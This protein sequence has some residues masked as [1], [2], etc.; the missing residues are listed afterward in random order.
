M[1]GPGF[2]AV[3][4]SGKRSSSSSDR[5]APRLDERGLGGERNRFLMVSN[6]M[7]VLCSGDEES[8]A[9]GGTGRREGGGQRPRALSWLRLTTLTPTTPSAMPQMG[10]VLTRAAMMAGAWAGS[11]MMAQATAAMVA[12]QVAAMA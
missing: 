6:M 5:P 11:A 12:V 9:V 2:Q 10:L 4:K 7:H 3:W 8:R 1:A